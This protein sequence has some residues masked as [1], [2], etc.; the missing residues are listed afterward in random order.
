MKKGRSNDERPKSREETPKWADGNF[1]AT[2]ATALSRYEPVRG[3]QQL[4]TALTA[5]IAVNLSQ[6]GNTY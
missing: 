6:G 4:M 1:G 5:L 3:M 2:I